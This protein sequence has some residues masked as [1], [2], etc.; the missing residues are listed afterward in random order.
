[1]N[2]LRNTLG[3]LCAVLVA[4]SV[5]AADPMGTLHNVNGGQ[6]R[7]KLQ[8]RNAAKE[9]VVTTDRGTFTFPADQVASVDVDRPAALDS[10]IKR[11]QSGSG[12][13][14]AVKTL[15]EIAKDYRHLTYD[16]EATQWLATAY[17]K[18]GKAAEA[19]KACETVIR[20]D[21]TAAY[22]GAMAVQY[23]EALIKDGKSGTQLNRHLE[24][25]IASGDKV[26][27]AS[28][29]VA[30]GDAIMARG[31]SRANCE[32]ALRDGYLRVILLY[33]DPATDAYPA[34]LYK[35]AQA[36]DGMGQG[37]RAGKLRET[38]KSACP[39]SDW[40]RK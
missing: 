7:G 11:V 37:A 18:E 23:W 10:A 22:T 24:K 25:A 2:T 14:S 27:A 20:D 40:A 12:L 9:Y 31:T 6:T 13:A 3:A 36:F 35:G 30:R 33:A 39:N 8:W 4:A 29:L 1:M 34:A 5:Q 26:A 16:K 17:L 21:P 38:L 28:A 19:I 32:E 15:E